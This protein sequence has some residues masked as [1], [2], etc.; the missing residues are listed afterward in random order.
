MAD[1]DLEGISSGGEELKTDDEIEGVKSGQKLL[2]GKRQ[3]I[4]EGIERGFD[5]LEDSLIPTQAQPQGD[6][7]AQRV[8]NA[9][10]NLFTQRLEIEESRIQP[11]S[12]TTTSSGTSTAA[13]VE[14]GARRQNFAI[15]YN[16]DTGDDD[17]EIEVSLDGESW[18]PFASL[19]IPN[20]GDRDVAT[21]QSVYTHIRVYPGDNFDDTDINLLQV[22]S[23]GDS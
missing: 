14:K 20:G 15:F 23:S 1:N 5:V 19:T 2:E 22:V 21:G 10:F 12:D 4:V 11:V 17:V 6:G 3:A 9:M 18:K 8:I 16:F 7:P 13:V